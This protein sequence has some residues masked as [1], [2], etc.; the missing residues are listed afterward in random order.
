MLTGHQLRLLRQLRGLGQKALAR[1]MNVSQ[2]RISALEMEDLL[3]DE[4]S[5]KILRTLKLTKDEAMRYLNNLPTSAGGG[6]IP[7]N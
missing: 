6:V 3:T 2:Q 4:C 1:K 7:V 5:D